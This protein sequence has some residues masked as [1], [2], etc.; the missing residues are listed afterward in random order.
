[1]WGQLVVYNGGGVVNQILYDNQGQ[2]WRRS[3][4]SW[5]TTSWDQV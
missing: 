1:M 3:I 4:N 5:G 2:I